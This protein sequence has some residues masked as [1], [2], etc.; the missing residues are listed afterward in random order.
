MITD[1]E[2]TLGGVAL[3]SGTRWVDRRNHPLVGQQIRRAL[4]G[5]IDSYSVAID[6]GQPVTLSIERPF[7]W[8]YADRL[9]ALRT[10]SLVLDAQHVLHWVWDET[11]TDY[12]IIFDHSEGPALEFNHI[13]TVDGTPSRIDRG[14]YEGT[15]RLLII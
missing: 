11:P 14:L 10:L 4:A 9:D 5:N 8:V 3:P 1:S 12:T 13:D 15:I 6:Q 7:S 2:H